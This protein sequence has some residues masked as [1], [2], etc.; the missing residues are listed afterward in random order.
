MSRYMSGNDGD[1]VPEQI[2][3]TGKW[4]EDNL[5]FDLPMLMKK[6]R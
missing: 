2:L 4:L 6:Q 5:S 3:T 1:V